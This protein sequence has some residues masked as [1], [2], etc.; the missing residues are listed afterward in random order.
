MLT[1]ANNDRTIKCLSVVALGAVLVGIF[2][3]GETGT[4]VVLRTTPTLLISKVLT[5]P[6]CE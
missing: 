5:S 1:I 4:A 6:R 2:E 3:L